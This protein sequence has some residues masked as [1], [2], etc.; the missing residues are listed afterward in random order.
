[1][2]AP[3]R[4]VVA[5]LLI[6][7]APPLAAEVKVS[8]DRNPVQ[9][10]ESFQ[11]VFSLDRMPDRDP[12]FSPLLKDFMIIANNRSNSISII[13]GE[14]RRSVKWTLQLM[15]KQIGEY[16]IP[17]IRFGNERS[18]AFD[19]TVKPSSLASVP[20][21]ELV[22]ELVGDR[23]RAF[24][25]QQV[26]VTLRLLSANDLSAF[27]FGDIGLSGVDAVVEP[28][29]DVRR[30]TT[31]I[32]DQSYL[33]LE[34]QVALF[35]QRGGRVEV[36][37]VMAEARLPSRSS[38]DPFRTGGE[39]RRLRSEPLA[40]DVDPIP[41]GWTGDVWLPATQIELREQ[42]QGDLGQLVPGE[43]VTRTV[44]LLADGLTAA[45]LPAVELPAVDGIKQYPDQASLANERAGDGIRGR[46]EQKVALI[47]S[48]AGRY[49]LPAVSLPWWN[50]DTGEI[51]TATLPAREFVV[52]PL[53]AGAGVPTAAPPDPASLP[54][55][56]AGIPDES[57]PASRFWPYLSLLLAC[58]WAMSALY[59]WWAWRR[60]GRGASATAVGEPESLAR[61]RRFLRDT[62]K[63]DDAAAARRAL[64]AWGRA[65]LA[66]RRVDN[67]DQLERQLGAEFGA[68][69]E[70]LNRVL[71]APGP[72]SW[73]GDS[74][75]RLCQ[76]LEAEQ[77]RAGARPARRLE[78]LNPPA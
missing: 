45:Q 7:L 62:C 43:P 5:A 34:K 2:V 19:I 66:P 13:N 18:E 28:L 25:Q 56:A 77:C 41:A 76:R 20:H 51:E 3:L 74:L 55:A 15:A 61:A 60:R 22:L 42:W 29:G 57:P 59:W 8:L 1:M 78:P 32:A 47:P 52:A 72:A 35:P 36:G 53:P 30:Y 75:W 73:E 50:L 48:A 39:I 69:I 63:R 17:A 21:D 10:N 54:S 65:L 70:R 38:F 27:Q 64:L 14:Y 24:V 68:E 9:V 71:Y 6:A 49:R 11:L 12:D 26:V 4:F 23:D 44:T 40:I 67:L 58:G 31:R 37:P 46:R 33:V 16:T